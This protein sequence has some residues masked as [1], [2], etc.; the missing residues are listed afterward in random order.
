MFIP[1]IGSDAV[2]RDLAVRVHE[3][4]HERVR[5]RR[6]E[7]PVRGSSLEGAAVAMQRRMQIV[8]NSRR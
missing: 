1:K 2:R 3:T 7:A 6:A 8:S 5:G 4:E